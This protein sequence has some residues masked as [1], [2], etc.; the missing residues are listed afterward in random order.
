MNHTYNRRRAWW[1]AILAGMASYLDAGAI[2]GTSIALVL[3][4]PSL[5]I[6][7]W[8]FGALFSLLT[9]CFATS[10]LVGGYLGDRFGRKRVFTVTL[11]FFAIGVGV[12]TFASGV[13]MLYAGVILTGLAVGADLPVSL[14]MAAE[15]ADESDRGK[16]VALSGV[17][18]LVGISAVT[19][20]SV[21]VG[22]MGEI[23]GRII[24]GHLLILAVIVLMLRTRLP[25]SAE[26]SRA[27][28]ALR[29][30]KGA[31]VPA[32]ASEKKR[33]SLRALF[34]PPLVFA[35][36]ATGLFYAVWN[37]GA[38]TLGGFS[39]FIYV[40]VAGSDVSSASMVGL[41]SLPLGIL[42]GLWFMRIV[43][44]PSRRGWFFAGA[45]LSTA[46]FCVPLLFGFNFWSLA[47]AD[48][49]FA[50][51]ISFAGESLYK[52]WTQELFPTLA[53][54]TAQG[55]TMAF[56][57]YV[58]A[59]FALVTPALAIEAPTTLYL[60]LAAAMAAS[61]LIGALW[62]PRLKQSSSDKSVL[63]EP[64]ED[65]AGAAG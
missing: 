1:T 40:N 8:T 57:R 4:A 31:G 11:A 30:D 33:G 65:R 52:V 10:A 59:A 21:V 28:T 25:E 37:L 15:A 38:N 34:T 41:V 9:L 24:Y 23:G 58:A 46:S 22:N 36:A 2:V 44:R 6:D 43:D 7:E 51:G 56:A 55:I 50:I 27:R 12:L 18:W 39:T 35:L 20:L 29:R 42:G 47:S 16:M 53:R 64:L 14:S 13:P 17:L 60:I 45:I 49:L 5:G 61:G 32:L 54:S 26:W 62:I 19:L 48:V 63:S 3:Y